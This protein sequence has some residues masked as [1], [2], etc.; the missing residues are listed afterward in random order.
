M[1][2]TVP[3][4]A[5]TIVQKTVQ[6]NIADW[7]TLYR[8]ATDY[9]AQ[10]RYLEAE[11]IYRQ[12]LKHPRPESMND[13]MYSYIQVELGR[14]LQSQGKFAEAIAIFQEVVTAYPEN[15][16]AK[17][18]LEQ[19]NELLQQAEM[20]IAKGLKAIQ[21]DPTSV[22]GYR[23]LATGLEAKKQLEQ[24]LAFLEE[25]LGH[26]LLQEQAIELARA[27]HAVYKHKSAIALYRQ[28]VQRYPNYQPAR[29]ELLDV[30]GAWGRPEEA[31]A[32]YREAIQQRPTDIWLYWRSLTTKLIAVGRNDE[33]RQIYEQLIRNQPSQPNVYLDLGN[34]L[35]RTK[36]PD[37]AL[38]VY[39]QAIQ[40][41]PKHRPSD[42]RCHVVRETSYDRFVKLLAK[43]KRLD[44]VLDI[45]DK[46]KLNPTQEM[47]NN[48]VVAL[49]Y[50]GNSDL[51]ALVYRR[52]RD[53]YPDAKIRYG[54]CGGDY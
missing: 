22:W 42:R 52:F 12:I 33:A 27:A 43:Q 49:E 53:R 17:N 7:S 29:S 31:I 38:Q 46:A 41:F 13:Y 1:G 54:S 50:E 4:Q 45:F 40:A 19:V 36:Q 44:R 6:T 48:L 20:D 25:K 35:E 24:G 8:Q 34:L 15:Y 5:R 39:L 47:Y 28:L 51:A 3:V 2:I 32:A 21:S 10:H 14:N 26:S 30:L 16:S 18:A 23:D 37:R 11:A 9:D